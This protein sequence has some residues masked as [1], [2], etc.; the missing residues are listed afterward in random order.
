MKGHTL[1]KRE[2]TLKKIVKLRSL[3]RN[4]IF[5]RVTAPKEEMPV[6][7]RELVCVE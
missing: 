1:F 3:S 2:I 7:S 5:S 6:F 4:I